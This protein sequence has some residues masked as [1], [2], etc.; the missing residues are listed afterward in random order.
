MAIEELKVFVER[1]KLTA[2]DGGR[3]KVISKDKLSLIP[4]ESEGELKFFD[5]SK[6]KK[7]IDE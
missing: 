4:I 7:G 5:F 3:S 1:R 2:D 6:R